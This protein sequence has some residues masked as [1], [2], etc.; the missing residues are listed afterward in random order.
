MDLMWTVKE[1]IDLFLV[2][3]F[4]SFVIFCTDLKFYLSKCSKVTETFSLAKFSMNF[5]SKFPG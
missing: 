1:L 2:E 5:F 4:G 3:C